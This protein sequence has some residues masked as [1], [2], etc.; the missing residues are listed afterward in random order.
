MLESDEIVS[1]IKNYLDQNAF[2]SPDFPD[3]PC[4]VPQFDFSDV[5]WN[6]ERLPDESVEQRLVR[7]RAELESRGC[8]PVAER[9]DKTTLRGEDGSVIAFALKTGD[10]SLDTTGE[11]I[12]HS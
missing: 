9:P 12:E 11:I 5:R 1:S 6:I 3:E 7:I 2:A 10:V 4:A 8:K